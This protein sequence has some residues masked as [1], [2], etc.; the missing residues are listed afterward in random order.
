MGILPFKYFPLK[1]PN[2]SGEYAS[3][4]TFSLLHISE[5]PISKSL[6]NNE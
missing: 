2:P 1:T 3:K 5:L 4:P 6:F